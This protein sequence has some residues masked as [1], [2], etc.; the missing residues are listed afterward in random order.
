MRGPRRHFTHS[1]VMCWV[2][3]DR[4][5]AIVETASDSTGPVEQW[6][7]IRDEIHDQVCEHAYN[8]ELGAFTQTYDST[9]STLRC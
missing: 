8:A 3:F 4:A 9:S 6:R 1:K 5:I 7:A 2:A